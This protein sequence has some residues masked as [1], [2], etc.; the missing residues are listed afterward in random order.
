MKKYG[1]TAQATDGNK[2]QRMRFACW[3]TKA[4]NTNSEYFMLLACAWQ[5][6]SCERA[7]LL[8]L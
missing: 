6:W 3:I 8:F 1:K 5:Q 4:T 2:K 7:S